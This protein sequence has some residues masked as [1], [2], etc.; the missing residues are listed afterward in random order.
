MEIL[1]QSPKCDNFENLTQYEDLVLSENNFER[2]L[3]EKVT[4]KRKYFL[5]LKG[6]FKFVFQSF[7]SSL[8]KHKLFA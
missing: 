4:K 3:V 6:A 5:S 1:I 8:W 7:F 2:T